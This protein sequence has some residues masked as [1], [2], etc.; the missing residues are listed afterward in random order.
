MFDFTLKILLAVARLN[1]FTRAAEFLNVS[2]PA[3]THQI[4]NLEAIFK[5]R[6]FNR[7]QNKIDLTKTGQVLVNYAE[8][9]DLLYQKASQEIMQMNDRVAGEIHLGVA[10]LLGKYLLPK[11]LGSFKKTYPDVD[12]SML[13]G[14]SKEIIGF[15]EK[16]VIELAIVSEPIPSKNLIAFPFYRD[17]MT[18]V[19]HPK[20]P[21]CKKGGITVAELCRGDFISREIG[22]ATREICSK[23]L[24]PA[25]KGKGP[26]PVMVL[27]SAEAIKTAIM[28]EMG[29]SILS[30]LAIHSEVELGL[31]REIRVKDVTMVRN[32]CVIYTAGKALSA[33]ALRL[34]DHLKNMR[35]LRPNAA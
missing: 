10:S 2:Q 30:R 11:I 3:V 24:Q 34:K 7:T 12:L 9:I 15:L 32:F 19:V 6:L 20:H 16:G 5:T 21:W 8:Q 35:D 31:L 33:P 18:V 1:S 22:S 29:Y 4:K 14:N 27:G 17:H 13:V 25:C 26:K 23:W 28:G